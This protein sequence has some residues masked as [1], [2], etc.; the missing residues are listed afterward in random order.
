MLDPVQHG[1]ISIK[2]RERT[3]SLH[4]LLVILCVMQPRTLLTFFAFDFTKLAPSHFVCTVLLK[5]EIVQSEQTSVLLIFF[6]QQFSFPQHAP[7]T[8]LYKL[9][10]KCFVTQGMHLPPLLTEEIHAMHTE[11]ILK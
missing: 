10:C 5:N 1:L 8:H 7:F 3:T 4:F 6:K 11:V 9:L 2:Q